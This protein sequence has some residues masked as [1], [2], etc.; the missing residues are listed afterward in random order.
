[1]VESTATSWRASSLSSRTSS[2]VSSGKS[3]Q[4]WNE[5]TMPTPRRSSGRYSARSM[6]SRR[7]L[8]A[9]GDTRP[10]ITSS[11]VVLPEPLAP[12]SPTME[13]G[14]ASNVTP[15]ERVHAAEPHVHALDP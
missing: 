14:S 10:E 7:T 2:T 3:R 13:P 12:I 1:M 4:S 9:C 6:S 11:V 8:P 15:F 5:R